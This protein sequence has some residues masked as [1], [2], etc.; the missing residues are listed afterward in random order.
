MTLSLSENVRVKLQLWDTAGQERFR[1]ITRTYYRNC[2]GCLIVYD[3]TNRESFEHVRDWLYEAK[4]STDDQDIVFL[5]VGHK[6]DLDYQREVTT[7]EGEAFANA[8]DMIFL[9][10]SAKILCN[11]EEAFIS[12]TKEIHRR[13]QQ[14]EI[15]Q[16]EG[17]DGIKTIPFRPGGLYVSNEDLSQHGESGRKCCRM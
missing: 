16:M 15:N 5:L 9:E 6:L 14:G 7:S 10:T 12:V 13:L 3:I 8:H 1:S 11:I 2:A 4:Q 17:W